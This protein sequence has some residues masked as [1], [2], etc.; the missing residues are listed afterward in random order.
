MTFWRVIKLH[1]LLWRRA[2]RSQGIKGLLGRKYNKI[3]CLDFSEQHRL[4]MCVRLL[5]QKVLTGRTQIPLETYVWRAVNSLI[6]KHHT[7]LLILIECAGVDTNHYTNTESRGQLSCSRKLSSVVFDHDSEHWATL[8]LFHCYFDIYHETTTYLR[9]SQT[10]TWAFICDL[11]SFVLRSFS[12][13]IHCSGYINILR[14]QKQGKQCCFRKHETPTGVGVCCC[15]CFRI[16]LKKR[17]IE[18][19]VSA[20]FSNRGRNNHYT[21]E[22]YFGVL[23]R[24]TSCHRRQIELKL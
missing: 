20:R 16:H 19:S 23:W 6:S 3:K 7:E 21:T 11:S 2:T 8:S 9:H 15:G 4:G 17:K 1:P 14:R 10:H 5:K 18:I 22:T 24:I 13:H 12:N